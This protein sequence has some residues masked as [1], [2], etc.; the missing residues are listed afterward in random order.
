MS[1]TQTL[2]WWV[3]QTSE[4]ETNIVAVERIMNY[5]KVDQEAPAKAD[6]ENKLAKPDEKWP[7]KGKVSF[8]NYGSVLKLQRIFVS[9]FFAKIF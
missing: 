8:K 9:L 5:G 4:I 1:I 3:R 2:N 7:S 6:D